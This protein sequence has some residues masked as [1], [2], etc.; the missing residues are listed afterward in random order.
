MQRI[1]ESLLLF[2]RVFAMDKNWVT[3]TSRLV[4]VELLPHDRKLIERILAVGEKK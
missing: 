1:D 4:Q 2:R 3:Q